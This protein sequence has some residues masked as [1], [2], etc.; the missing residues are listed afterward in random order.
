MNEHTSIDKYFITTAYPY[1]NGPLHIGHGYSFLRCDLKNRFIKM[2][3]GLSDFYMGFHSSGLPITISVNKIKKSDTE[4]INKFELNKTII[5]EN[6]LDTCDGWVKY[7]IQKDLDALSMLKL[8]IN[9]DGCF[10]TTNLEKFYDSFIKWTFDVFFKKNYIV[11]K[12]HKIIYCNRCKTPLGD[13]DRKIGEGV[14]LKQYEVFAVN[15]KNIKLKV[16]VLGKP[17]NEII[18]PDDTFHIIEYEDYNVIVSNFLYEILKSLIEVTYIKPV[19]NIKKYLK[20]MGYK[21]I[22][23]ENLK[24]LKFNNSDKN[25]SSD[26]DSGKIIHLGTLKIF[27]SE[28]ICRCGFKGTVKILKNQYFLKYSD[29]NLKEL[30]KNRI[31]NNEDLNPIIKSQV[32][33]RLNT[34]NDWCFSRTYGLGTVPNFEHN[35][36]IDSLSDSTIYMV[37]HPLVK[38]LRT[39]DTYPFKLWDFIFYGIKSKNYKVCNKTLNLRKI[40]LD[41]KTSNLHI[42]GKDLVENHLIFSIIHHTVLFPTLKLPTY[43][44]TSHLKIENNKMSKSSGNFIKI[45]SL[46]ENY[47]SDVSRFALGYLSDTYK[48]INFSLKTVKRRKKQLEKW[49]SDV[50]KI[51][52]IRKISIKSDL[53]YWLYTESEK[54]FKVVKM[55]YSSNCFRNAIHYNFFEINKLITTYKSF[56]LK[57]YGLLKYIALKQIKFLKILFPTT[58][59]EYNEEPILNQKIEFVEP[60]E[61]F[62]KIIKDIKRIKKKSTTAKKILITI[63]KNTEKILLRPSIC[64]ILENIFNIKIMVTMLSSEKSLYKKSPIL[65]LY[66][67]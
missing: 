51:I 25:N 54:F 40:F 42:I 48:D 49:F 61:V 38:I 23:H 29:I 22:T 35:I 60:V 30:I 63:T 17:S 32:L 34:L 47:G 50:K 2:N 33:N 5:S 64:K 27:D 14:F 52:G 18:I 41:N 58:L 10:T 53:D 57:N 24:I 21:V 67:E 20:E 31:V 15:L 11:K 19:T 6:K 55:N 16:L 39:L 43:Y 36:I 37:L 1:L 13:H 9:K 66:Y 44:V 46:V 26:I 28:V 59:K 8:D 4:F 62:F 65:K 45:E 12:D 7:F 56:N 3:K